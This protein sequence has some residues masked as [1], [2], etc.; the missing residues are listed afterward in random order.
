MTERTA[1]AP[2]T[3]KRRSPRTATVLRWVQLL[4]GMLISAY[5]L[6]M[7]DEGWS[8]TVNT[9]MGQGVVAFVAW[10]G[11]IRWQLPRYRRWRARRRAPTTSGV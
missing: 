7:P 3:P 1:T 6:F 9:V 8:D 11:V 5:F 10:T 2:L 4:A